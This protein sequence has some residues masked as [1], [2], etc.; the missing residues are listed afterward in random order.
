MLPDEL[1][2]VLEMLGYRWPTA[3][4]DKLR[5]SAQL[6]R[7]FGDDVTQLHTAANTSARTVTAHNAGQS[8]DAFTKVYAKFDGGGGGDGYLADAAQAA[9]IIAGVMDAC[10]YLVEFAKWAVIA[11]LIALA[12]EI[13]AAQLAAPFTFGLSEVGALGATQATRLIV[14]RLL[15]ELKEAL[16]EAIVEAMK[17]PAVSAIEAIITDLVRQSVNVGFGAQQGYDLSQTAKA[18]AQGGWEAIKQTPQTLVEGVRD[19]LGSKAGNSAHHAVDSRIDGYG[20]SSSETPSSGGTGSNGSGSSDASESSNDSGSSDGSGSSGSDSSSSSTRSGIGS[21]ISADTGGAAVGAPDIGSGPDS[22]AGSGTDSGQGTAS[23]DTSYP[24]PTPSTTGPTLSDFD[25]PSPGAAPT[26]TPDSGSTAGSPG[27]SHTGG[28]SSVSGLSSPTP[29]AA[30][31]PTTS[32]GGVSAS[33]GNGSGISTNIDSLAASVPTQSAAAPTPTADPSPAGTGSRTDGGSAMP[34]SPTAPT[35]AGGATAGTRPATHTPGAASSTAGPTTQTGAARMPTA[36][37]P[38]TGSAPGT[39]TATGPNPATSG[40]ARNPA[41]HTGTTTGPASTPQSTPAST[42]RTSPSTPNTPSTSPS[43]TSARTPGADGRMPGSTDSRPGTTDNRTPD[44]RTPGSTNPR[45]PGT[46][47]NRTPHQT[48]PHTTPTGRTPAP[49]T[50]EGTGTSTPSPT[51]RQ[52]ASTPSAATQAPGQATPA[53]S[54]PARTAP[55]STGTPA[56]TPTTNPDRTST[57]SSRTATPTSQPGTTAPP[58]STTPARPPHQ[59]TGN[60]T[61]APGTPGTPT[62][63]RTPNTPQQP[64]AQSAPPQSTPH[65]QQQPRD[66]QVTAVPIPTPMR[67]PAPASTASPT[68]AAPTSPQT[69]GSPD[70]GTPATPHHP[71]QDSLQDIRTDL[72]HSPGGLTS[73]DPADQQALVDAVPHD[74]NGTPQRF[75]DPFGPWSQLQND[76]GPTVTGRSNNCA[77]CSRSF[78]ETW[79]GNPQVSAAR[80]PDTDA[81]G[82]PDTWSPEDNA[83]DNQ[84]RWTGATHTYAGPGGDP[85][86]ADAIADTLRQAGPGSAAIVQVDWPGGG[87]HAYN[88]VNHNGTIVWVD[89]QSGQVS[90][91]PLHIDQAAHVWHIPL[92]ANRDPID[93]SQPSTQESGQQSDTSAKDTDSHQQAGDVPSVEQPDHQA[94]TAEP[95]GE[96]TDHPTDE[97]ADCGDPSRPDQLPAT[98]TRDTTPPGGVTHPTLAEQNALDNAVPRDENGDPTRPPDPADGPWVQHINGTGTDTPGR[99]NNCADVALSTV[100]TY[101]GHPTAAAA[102][103]PDPNPDGTPSDRGERAGRDRIENTL[104]ARFTDL[105]N[106]REAFDRLEHTLRDSGHGSQAVILTQD[107]D[108]RAHAWNAV[109]HNGRIA[110]IDA[111]TGRTSPH[112]LHSGSNGVFAIPLDSGR[113]PL[114]SPPDVAH[115]QA[116]S[117][118]AGVQPD[119]G[120]EPVPERPRGSAPYDVAQSERDTHYGMLPEPSQAELRSTNDVFQTD[121]TPVHDRLREWSSNGELATLLRDGLADEQGGVRKNTLANAL[122]GF[123]QLT[124]GQQGAVVA[125]LARMDLRFHATSAV[126]AALDPDADNPNAPANFTPH[127]TD[128]EKLERS[129]IARKVIGQLMDKAGIKSAGVH[130]HNGK[131]IPGRAGLVAAIHQ[132]IAEGDDLTDAEIAEAAQSEIQSL[133]DHKG[134]WSRKNFAVVEVRDPE[135]NDEVRYI[136]DSSLPM[137]S[138]WGAG[139]HS[140]P[141]AMEWIEAVNAKR[142]AAGERPYEPVSLYTEREPCG[143]ASGNDCSGYLAHEVEE[144]TPDDSNTGK[145]NKLRIHYGVGFRRGQIDPEADL[146]RDDGTTATPEEAKEEARKRFTG[147][148]N[149]YVNHLK[150]VWETN[151]KAGMM[152]E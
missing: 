3:D 105:G 31:A 48:T 145:K 6:W 37:S 134:D 93:T 137:S 124:E 85:A 23:S 104:D 133:N 53:Q 130:Y 69:P 10:A 27:T 18:G 151:V 141:H 95:T 101:A 152:N 92:D 68:Q 72:D 143:H 114:S 47:D 76:G 5:E 103:T 91:Q 82:N 29:H 33:S 65:P 43:S 94:T 131:A 149:N 61:P 25:D 1:E 2:W 89:T 54:S 14:R 107:A 41:A 12:I 40:P 150:S 111:Q 77:D 8:I 80:T 112:P 119:S 56:T 128:P 60:N 108:G 138:A 121:L 67:T 7:Q 62:T 100:D 17:E 74:E 147:D 30:A 52:N 88:A 83:N 59:P 44:S 116:P 81:A 58:A 144:P 57:P 71:A 99:N 135:N 26:S 129:N 45:T 118:P 64:A 122:T 127:T 32:G 28:G 38:T 139:V 125:A 142:E 13:A 70:T 79:Y 90:H 97:G 78:L 117:A 35:T 63:P 123:A 20:N 42:P 9:H 146:T 98:A 102:R 24:R 86:T 50:P 120:N 109:N 22:G 126:G 110:Y 46:A 148:F 87:G 75:T 66:N 115:R 96:T 19:S 4:E 113:R 84:I 140:E 11:Q 49:S 73:P 16:M 51:P 55:P 15:D 34:A 21:G 132:R 136:V 106:G 36:G 39:A